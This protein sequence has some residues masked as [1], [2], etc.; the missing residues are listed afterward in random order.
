MV[1]LFLQPYYILLFSVIAVLL[2]IVMKYRKQ[3]DCKTRRLMWVVIT[4]LGIMWVLSTPVISDTIEKS[5]Y[6]NSSA[7]HFRPEVIVILAGGYERGY[8]REQDVLVME[9]NIRVLTGVKWWKGNPDA[10][11]VISGAGVLDGRKSSR[12]T[13]L[14]TAMAV[15]AG[16]PRNRIIADTLS[17]NTFEHP[18]KIMELPGIN[19][20]TSVGVVTSKWHMRRAIFSFKQYF[21]EVY[22]SPI[23][24]SIIDNSLFTIQRFIP[25]PDALS[26]STTMIHEWIGLLCYKIK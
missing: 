3:L 22:P 8:S 1:K 6:L 19:P 7:E 18:Q 23:S 25:H 26:K 12:Q 16:V 24:A 11:M 14:M 2:W 5:L 17:S 10:I 21:D 15:N 4:L 20:Q 9:T 13:E